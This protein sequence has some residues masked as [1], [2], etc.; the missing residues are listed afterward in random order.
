MNNTEKIINSKLKNKISDFCVRIS[1]NIWKI[2]A[3]FSLDMIFWL[4]W[5]WNIQL[6]E[7]WRKLNEKI[8]IKQTVKR[9]SKNLN[10]FNANTC[11]QLLGTSITDF[12]YDTSQTTTAYCGKEPDNFFLI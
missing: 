1:E 2:E 11:F 4:I 8:S 6:S 12:N 10:N 5:W 9:L 7:I 3:K